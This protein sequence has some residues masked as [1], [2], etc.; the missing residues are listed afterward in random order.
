[1]RRV[2]YWLS[3]VQEQSVTYSK[4]SARHVCILWAVSCI[5]TQLVLGFT[6]WFVY[7]IPVSWCKR[8]FCTTRH[9]VPRL[10]CLYNLGVQIGSHPLNHVIIWFPF[11]LLT[12]WSGCHSLLYSGLSHVLTLVLISLTTW[13]RCGLNLRDLPRARLLV[14]SGWRLIH[15]SSGE[16]LLKNF[17]R[18]KIF[19]I[20]YQIKMF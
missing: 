9:A 7:D 16:G 10:K 17:T 6:T 12:V 8:N 1:M 19:C 5:C 3:K 2:A 4:W 20:R 14:R 11:S 13:D 15:T 18:S